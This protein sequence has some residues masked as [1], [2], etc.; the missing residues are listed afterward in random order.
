VLGRA[1]RALP[2]TEESVEELLGEDGPAA[3]LSDVPVF[4]RRLPDSPLGNALRLLLLQLP[5]SRAAALDALYEDGLEALLT[6]GLARTEDDRVVARGRIVPAEGLLLC[7][8]GFTR[9]EDDP[10][11]WV[12]SYTPTASWLAALTPRRRVRRA[13]DIGTGSGAQA[14]IATRHADEVIATDVNPRALHFTAISAAR[15]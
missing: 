4:D 15:R 9:G 5:I 11:G 6:L 3:G 7:F 2:Y 1:L 13:L 8:D 12:A 14:L 10:P